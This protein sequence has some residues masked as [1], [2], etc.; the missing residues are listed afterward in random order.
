MH[1]KNRHWALS[2][3]IG[4]GISLLIAVFVR[5][6]VPFILYLLDRWQ[7]STINTI[8]LYAMLFIVAKAGT[9]LQGRRP[10]AA[11]NPKKVRDKDATPKNTPKPVGFLMIV[12]S[13]IGIYGI[14]WL[15]PALI[16]YWADLPPYPPQKI[17]LFVY[18][19]SIASAAVF[20][21]ANEEDFSTWKDKT[22][23]FAGACL[24]PV[25]VDYL[26]S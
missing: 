14:L 5:S 24:G 18:L 1:T 23:Y 7:V 20:L 12:W 2:L 21:F 13:F 17:L 6:G 15:T 10:K 25:I 16:I 26:L 8:V 9:Q 22:S 19:L 3:L 4:F 11:Q